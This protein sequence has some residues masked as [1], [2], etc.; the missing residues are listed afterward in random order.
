[1]FV[2]IDVSINSLKLTMVYQKNDTMYVVS[3]AKFYSLLKEWWVPYI[4]NACC[5]I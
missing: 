2:Q 3:Q 5:D 4:S 1:M